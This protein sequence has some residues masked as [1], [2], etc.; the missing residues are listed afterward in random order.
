MP[1][2][3]RTYHESGNPHVNFTH[4]LSAQKVSTFKVSGNDSESHR[5]GIKTSLEC[6]ICD[7]KVYK[8]CHDSHKWY[9]N[10]LRS[11]GCC[12]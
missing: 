5:S 11:N 6:I 9:Y 12:E 4:D 7:T 3:V 1:V 10:L 2:S 8:I